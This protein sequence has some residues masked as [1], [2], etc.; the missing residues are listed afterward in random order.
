MAP[1][2]VRRQCRSPVCWDD[3]GEHRLFGPNLLEDT[4]VRFRITREWWLIAQSR[5]RS[6]VDQ[7]QHDLEFRVGVHMPLKVSPSREIKRFADDNAINLRNRVVPRTSGNDQASNA[8]NSNERNVVLPLE[9][10][11]SG[12]SAQQEPSLTQALGQMTQVLQVLDQNKAIRNTFGV[13]ARPVMR[14]VFQSPYPANIDIKHPYPANEKLPK[15]NK[16]FSDET[17][18]TVEHVAWFTAQC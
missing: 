9:D 16:F 15:F 1:N 5:Q 11:T 12:Q 10:E 18:N 14:P 17:K 13:R 2:N 4:E 7:G 8:N 6:Y 3:I